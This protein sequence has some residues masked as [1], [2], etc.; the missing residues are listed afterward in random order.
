MTTRRI[1][2]RRRRAGFTLV[3]L[4]VSLV[5]GTLV[6]AAVFSLG[7]A[8]SRHFQ[9]QQ[10]IGVTQR[11]V[12]MAMNRIRRDVSRAGYLHVSSELAPTVRTCTTPAIP[13]PVPAVQLVDN[14]PDGNAALDAIN[15]GANRTSSDRLR[16]TGGYSTG[17]Q[18]L[19]RSFNAAGNQIFLQ[20]NWFAFRRNFVST[21]GG[22]TQ[23][24][25]AHFDE[26]FQDGRMLHIET[27]DGTHYFVNI[28]GR[29][30]DSAGLSAQI[31]IA[32]G[33]GVDNPCL[34]GLGRGA[35]I[36]PLSEV[37]YIIDTAAPGSAL[38]PQT[39]AV[40]GA[41]TILVRRE[42]D[43]DTNGVIVGS[44]RP[45]LEWAVDFNVDFVV[46]TNLVVGLPPTLQIVQGAAAQAVADN[47]PWQLRTAI[48]TIAARTP[49]QDGR[50]P[51]PDTWAGSRPIGAPLNRYQVFPGRQGAA[52]VRSLVTEI[53]MPNMIPR[54]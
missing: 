43:M 25:T 30:A 14:D 41:N 27:P 4:M 1:Q 45:V 37:E 22:T 8:S 3:E 51:W 54:Q 12:R 48:I 50:F 42:L 31:N 38:A 24:D 33:L 21:V 53:Q 29:A 44:T 5:I 20:T 34:D 18:Y 49:D 10:R 23:V 32:P 7:G 16:L 47:T 19:V 17:D 26:V 35:L 46:D 28:N 9:E 39:P 2:P 40:T 36:T 52:R 11:S 15:R 6:V 13:T